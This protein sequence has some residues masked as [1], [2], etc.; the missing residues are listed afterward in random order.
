ML[1]DYHPLIKLNQQEI[2]YFQ[3]FVTHF[4][5]LQF[6]FIRFIFQILNLFFPFNYQDFL[7]LYLFKFPITSFKNI[8]HFLS[9]KSIS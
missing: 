8:F 7:T 3:F 4:F 1:L 9:K 5:D 6:N 2:K